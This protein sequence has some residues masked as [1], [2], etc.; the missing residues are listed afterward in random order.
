MAT[1]AQLTAWLATAEQ[2]EFDLVTGGKAV[3]VSSSSGKSVS[4]TAA[5]LPQLQ[6]YIASLRRQLGIASTPRPLTFQ[7]GGH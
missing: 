5:S 1:T 2:A 7:I 3:S 6:A 4:Y